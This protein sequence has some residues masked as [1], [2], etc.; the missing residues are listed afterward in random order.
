M[1]GNGLILA[2]SFAL[3]PFGGVPGA[4]VCMLVGG[5][6]NSITNVLLFTVVQLIIPRHLL[7]RV[8]GLL[9]FGSFG[10]YP[11]S[12]ALVGILSTRFGPANL[13]PFGGL[14]LALILL[15]AMTQRAVR[16]L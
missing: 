11:I 1:L 16:E 12:A 4:V 2:V 3:L 15:L 7:G 10:M 6:A 13:F 5:A 14:L 9:M 8:M